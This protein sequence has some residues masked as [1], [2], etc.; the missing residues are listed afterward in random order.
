[1]L[2]PTKHTHIKYSIVYISGI[3]LKMLQENSILKYDEMKQLLIKNIG[4]KAKSRLN[5]SLTFLYSIGKIGYLKE[6]DAITI[7]NE[8]ENEIS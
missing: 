2:T 6:L 8:Q 4:I 3:I 1:M 5:I 7:T